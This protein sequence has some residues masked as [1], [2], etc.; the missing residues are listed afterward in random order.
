M[1][2]QF[3]RI[4]RYIKRFGFYYGLLNYYRIQW[5]K[6]GN[7]LID[8]PNQIRFRPRTSD[9]DIFEQVFIEQEYKVELINNSPFIID[10]GANIGFTSIYLK[11]KFPQATVVSIEPEQE[12][13]NFLLL[14][15][16]PYKQTFPLKTALWFE[17][18]E[19]SL[20][21]NTSKDSHSVITKS[22]KNQNTVSS[23]TISEIMEK[24][25]VDCIDLLKIDIEGA[26]KYV[27]DKNY[28]TWL[29]K[30]KV[31]MIELHDKI[32]QGCSKVVFKALS[33][34]NFEVSFKGEI[35]ICKN[36]DI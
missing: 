19:L 4:L 1:I 31:I 11:M 13:F 30:V 22:I 21:I 14:N 36:F 27:F 25:K 23:I 5:S 15:L 32:L 3:L 16:A 7:I 20:M 26:E 34:F 24:F 29:P 18:T 6:K 10:A 8:N 12:N 35:M 2:N 33:E 17:T 9:T 28:H